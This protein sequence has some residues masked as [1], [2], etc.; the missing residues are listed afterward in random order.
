MTPPRGRTRVNLLWR[1]G[2]KYEKCSNFFNPRGG[3][4]HFDPPHF[5]LLFLKNCHIYGPE[6]FSSWRYAYFRCFNPTQPGGG[7][8]IS[9]PPPSPFGSHFLTANLTEKSS[10][11]NFHKFYW[12]TYKNVKIQK[13]ILSLTYYYITIGVTKK[14]NYSLWS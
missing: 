11:C 3:G 10:I 6:C 14:C 5:L 13:Y 1:L 7:G 9:A 12:G 8:V 2:V 4:G